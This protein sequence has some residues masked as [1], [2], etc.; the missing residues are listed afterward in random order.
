MRTGGFHAKGSPYT[1][2]QERELKTLSL[3]KPEEYD[4][5]DDEQGIRELAEH[6]AEDPKLAED[7]MIRDVYDQRVADA[8]S[9]LVRK[10]PSEE[11]WLEPESDA[12][13]DAMYEI[14]EQA[15]WREDMH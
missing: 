5:S 14:D 4:L 10:D 2:S 7:T 3:V 6:D 15:M 1:V 11:I 12:C 9:P 8:A 13:Q